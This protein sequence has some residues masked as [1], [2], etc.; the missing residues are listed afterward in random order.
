MSS[1][2]INKTEL[3]KSEA[4]ILGAVRFFSKVALNDTL[5][6]EYNFVEN[7]NALIKCFTILSK[8]KCFLSIPT[9]R[10]FISN[11]R[12]EKSHNSSIIFLQC[13]PLWF[14]PNRGGT[15]FEWL[16]AYLEYILVSKY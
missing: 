13:L 12:G 11:K 3:A 2:I 10:Y 15:I 5:T 16:C 1:A 14:S 7:V 6:V 9:V 4:S 8:G